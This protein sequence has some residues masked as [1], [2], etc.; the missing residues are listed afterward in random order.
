MLPKH[1]QLHVNKVRD[2]HD[3]VAVAS[4]PL[5]SELQPRLLYCLFR[6]VEQPVH[7]FLL[8]WLHCFKLFKLLE[9]QEG[10]TREE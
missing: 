7:C 6:A 9:A 4:S 3:R 2:V 10:F 8:H 1:Y 5:L